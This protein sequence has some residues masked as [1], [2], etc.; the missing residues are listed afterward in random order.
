MIQAVFE[1]PIN[2][3]EGVKLYVM[4]TPDNIFMLS[5]LENSLN[6][7][8]MVGSETCQFLLVQGLQAIKANRFKR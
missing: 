6:A 3:G 2:M 7:G 8:G 1:P 4:Y 5:S